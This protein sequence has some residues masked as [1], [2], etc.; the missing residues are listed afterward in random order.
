MVS[1]CM[2]V[3]V[4]EDLVAEEKSQRMGLGLPLPM[5]GKRMKKSL[6]V[7][8]KGLALRAEVG[9]GMRKVGV[10][11][12]AIVGVLRKTGETRKLVV[13]AKAVGALEGV[14]GLEG[15]MKTMARKEETT[16]LVA[17]GGEVGVA[18]EMEL[19]KMVE[20]SDLVGVVKMEGKVEGLEVRTMKRVDLEGV[21]EGVALEVAQEITMEREREVAGMALVE[22]GLVV[23]VDVVMMV[24]GK[25]ERA[26]EE[27]SGR[28]RMVK[29][30]V[31]RERCGLAVGGGGGSCGLVVWR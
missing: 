26:E 23:E 31:G 19:R 2:C 21:V 12:V 6:L 7:E 15:A 28:M 14:G 24:T 22:E 20:A 29:A 18:G 30:S 8:V 27:A 17:L 9:G 16:N 11:A 10:D 3:Q 5:V 1:V 4:E 25:R 13:L